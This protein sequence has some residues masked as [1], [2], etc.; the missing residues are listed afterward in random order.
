MALDLYAAE[1]DQ[2]RLAEL[3]NCYRPQSDNPS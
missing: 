3:L 1:L 2:D